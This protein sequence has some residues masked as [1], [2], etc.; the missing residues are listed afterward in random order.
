MKPIIVDLLLLFVVAL[1]AWGACGAAMGIGLAK[2]TLRTTLTIHAVVAVVGFGATSWLYFG[3]LERTLTPLQGALAFTAE[4]VVLDALVVAL[5]I[6]RSF[7]MFKS[8]AGTWLPFLLIFA[9][10]WAA[11]TLAA[12]A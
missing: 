12:P 4:V 8:I 11:A 7:D 9:V 3:F 5:L 1:P 10:T 6:L 2:T